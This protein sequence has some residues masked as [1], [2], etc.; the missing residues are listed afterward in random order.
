MELALIRT[1]ITAVRI[2]SAGVSSVWRD[3]LMND[4]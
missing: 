2:I 1:E 3:G 4:D